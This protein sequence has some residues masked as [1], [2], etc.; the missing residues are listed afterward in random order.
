MVFADPPS[1]ALQQALQLLA[2]GKSEDAETAVKKAAQSAKAKHGSGSPPLAA[3][4]ADIAQLHLKMGQYGKAA[5]EFQHACKAPLPADP[6]GRQ[7]R[8]GFMFGFAEALVALG[9]FEEAEKVHRQCGAFARNLF[10]AN[11][12]RAVATNVPL[13]DG[14]LKAGKA[15]EALAAAQ[16]AYD[17]LWH[18]GDALIAFAVPVRAEALKAAGRADNPFADLADLPDELTHQAVAGVLTRAGSGD[19]VHVRAVLADLLAFADQKYGDGHAVM[20][21]VL[22]AVAHHEARQ[23][24]RADATVRRAAVRRSVWAFVVRRL[25]GGL[26]ANLEIGFEPN[27][28]I[29]LVPH[30][31]REPSVREA[32]QLEA[33]LTEAVDDLYSR[34][35][36][37][38]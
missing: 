17:A 31:S 30:V 26:L 1:A 12:P 29:H 10:G 25:P 36:L 7:A 5:V 37:P 24:D 14:L 20:C 2:E 4:Y 15:D 11:A 9:R 8:L 6:A 19:P 32:E 34:P 18:L 22:A 23:G 21:D 27:G 28:T 16:E 38:A 13:A 33:V 35:A 3:A